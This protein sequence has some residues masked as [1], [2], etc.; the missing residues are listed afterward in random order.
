MVPILDILIACVEMY[1]SLLKAKKIQ[2]ANKG[3]NKILL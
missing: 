3:E 1:A 2:N